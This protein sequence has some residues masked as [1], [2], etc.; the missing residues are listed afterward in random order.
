MI[1]TVF[2]QGESQDDLIPAVGRLARLV[3][4]E[5]AKKP[6]TES[7]A[8]PDAS[9][10]AAVPVPAAAKKVVPPA[11]V[12]RDTGGY[13]VHTG[14][15]LNN[16]ESWTSD[17]LSGVFSS[18]ALGRTLP[19]GERELFVAGEHSI[20][21]FL[22]GSELKLVAEIVIPL[23]AKILT[24]DTADLDHDGA[25]E[26][27]VTIMDRE[28][29]SSRVYQP[30]DSSLIMLADNLP[31]F[32]RGVGSDLKNRSIFTQKMTTG[33]DYFNGIDELVKNGSRFETRNTRKLPRKGNIFNFTPFRDASGV[34]KG[35]MLDEDGYL[36][37]YSAD[38]SELWKSSEK[39][40]GSATN[41]KHETSGPIR[42][43][44]EQ[45]DVHFLEQRITALPN[46]VLL[47]PHNEGFFNV[48]YNR[49]YSK[50]MFHALKWNGALYKEIWHT[51][52]LPSYLADYAYDPAAREVLLLEVVQK[53]GLIGSGK[54]A[55]SINR[56]E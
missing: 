55:I 32:F 43:M 51:Q 39:Y 24:M 13:V 10:V 14:S 23:P 38:G 4:Q 53:A 3:E 56:I 28:N 29:L 9:T 18:I 50:H 48:G 33:G 1:S 40:G 45:L 42:T 27:Y 25:P 41:F 37:I 16:S 21:F 36:E 5:L 22:K 17:P 35:A 54:T 44:G 8:S 20:L 6:V 34:E 26:L 31:W 15:S 12:A 19:S 11:G 52:S 7:S 47:V 49:A 2:E 30:K 46:G